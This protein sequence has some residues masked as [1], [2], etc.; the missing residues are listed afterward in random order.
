MLVNGGGE[1][2]RIRIATAVRWRAWRGRRFAGELAGAQAPARDG[3]P[4]ASAP[5]SASSG[6][7][8]TGNASHQI[9]IYAS[10]PGTAGVAPKIALVYNSGGGN[11]WIGKGWSISGLSAV[12][13]CR[14][15]R[16]A[17]DFLD[18]GVPVDGNSR[19]VNYS[20]LD[21]PWLDGARLPC[22]RPA[23]TVRTAPSIGWNSTPSHGS[24][25]SAATTAGR[26][27]TPGLI[28][29][30]SGARMAR[31]VPMA[32]PRIRGSGLAARE[33]HRHRAPVL[34]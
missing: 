25:R 24:H 11:G 3:L 16:E 29:L 6:V 19:P 21:A 5:R 2:N 18:A 13:R 31:P 12:T 26:R 20:N 4:M 15:T 8:E 7:D 9:P 17:G 28:P 33:G 27:L 23:P 10:T 1:M 30:L 32:T 34:A 14:K 22:W